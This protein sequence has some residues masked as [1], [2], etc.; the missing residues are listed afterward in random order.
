MNMKV[1]EITDSF[2]WLLWSDMYLRSAQLLENTCIE[3]WSKL[4][5]ELSSIPVKEKFYR[6]YEIDLS[7]QDVAP[8]LYCHSM[9]LFLKG[10]SYKLIPLDDVKKNKLLGKHNLSLWYR[11]LCNHLKIE[12]LEHNLTELD[13]LY[14]FWICQ[15]SVPI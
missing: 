4:S 13:S 8:Y 6:D 12:E 1:C 2:K 9:E 11:L 14:H 10:L 3:T 15:N 5:S 7:L